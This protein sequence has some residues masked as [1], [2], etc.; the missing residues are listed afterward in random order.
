M[1]ERE[2][3]REKPHSLHFSGVVNACGNALTSTAVLEQA[4]WW[5]IDRQS[6]WLPLPLK[7]SASS[8]HRVPSPCPPYNSHL[9]SRNRPMIKMLTMLNGCKTRFDP[10]KSSLSLLE[11]PLFCI[12]LDQSLD[13]LPCHGGTAQTKVIKC[14]FCPL[15]FLQEATTWR[16]GI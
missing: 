10:A 15:G 13:S 2:R 16:T 5:L 8:S 9:P 6:F 3:K 4:L 12:G 14:L 11:R 7:E 1:R